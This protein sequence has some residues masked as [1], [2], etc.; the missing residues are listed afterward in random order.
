MDILE[1]IKQ[2]RETRQM[3]VYEL[4]ERSGIARNTIY[5]WYSHN[6]TPSID[7]LQ[8]ICEK[9]FEISLAEFFA[10]D[11]DVVVATPENREIFEI[12]LSLSETQ[13]QA[14]KQIIQS[15]RK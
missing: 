12:W 13:R 3:S 4:A 1:R 15:Y 14:V 5:R 6:F 10:I 2:I 9:G 11:S 8:L 7:T